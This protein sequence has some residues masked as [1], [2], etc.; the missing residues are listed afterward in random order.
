[1][2]TIIIFFNFVY[3]WNAIYDN[4]ILFGWEGKTS[5]IKNLLF[6]SFVSKH[7]VC[8]PPE[9]LAK[10]FYD[11]IEPLERKKQ[12]AL[13]ENSKLESLREWLLPMLMNGQV[14][15]KESA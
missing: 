11:F 15:F 3:Q 10:R 8:M 5:G 2:L 12:N 7:N 13:N 6:D 4:D 14:T 9:I 1:M